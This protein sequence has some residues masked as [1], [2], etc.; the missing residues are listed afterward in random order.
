MVIFTHFKHNRGS[1]ISRRLFHFN[2]TYLRKKN[3]SVTFKIKIKIDRKTLISVSTN[4]CSSFIVCPDCRD[5][6]SNVWTVSINK[7]KVR[8]IKFV[9]TVCFANSYLEID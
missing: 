8:S 5:Q 1:T 3:V 4:K 7:F 9:I 2:N 6:N